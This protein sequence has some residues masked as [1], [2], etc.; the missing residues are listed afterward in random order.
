[1]E[2]PW[3]DFILFYRLLIEY[4]EDKGN[5]AD[6][7]KGYVYVVCMVVIATLHGTA[8]Q[9]S[10]HIAFKSAMRVHTSIIGV[11]YAKVS[12]LYVCI[13]VE[14]CN[15]VILLSFHSN[16][17]SRDRHQAPVVQRLANT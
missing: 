17:M 3:N 9:H 2:M 14:V 12:S 13:S 4:T 1:M 8:V 5:D 10:V 7:W 6:R 16:V 11:V 15:H